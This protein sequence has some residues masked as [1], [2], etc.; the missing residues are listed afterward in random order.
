MYCRDR[1]EFNQRHAYRLIDSAQVVENVS[2]GT[3]KPTNEAQ[4]SPLTK[5][6]TPEMQQD[7]WKEAIET[8]EE[9]EK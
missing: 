2:H 8:A 3:Q 9:G 6:P 5:L 1:W 7:E 4:A